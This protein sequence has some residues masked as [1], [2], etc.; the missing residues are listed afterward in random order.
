MEASLRPPNADAKQAQ[1]LAEFERVMDML[2]QNAYRAYRHL[3]YETPG[4]TDYF[5]AATP[6]AEIAELNIGSRPASRKSTRRIEDLR[7]IPWSF[8]WGQCRL[9][10]PGWYGFGSA[11]DQWLNDESTGSITKKRTLLRAML[12]E[13]P[14]FST[15]LSNMDMVLSKTDLALASRYASLVPD[16]K[17]RHSIFARI[18]AEH[19]KTLEA[20][21]MITGSRERLANNPTLARSIKNRIPYLDP[22]NHLQVELIKRHRSQNDQGREPDIRVHRGIHLSI[23]GVAAGLRNTG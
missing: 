13:W 1:R 5:F 4:F 6:I 12:K 3:V 22:L 16:R 20:L 2:S 15:L 8:S 11:V 7:A 21:W 18:A 10:L 9:L 23:N 14:F 17:L 19:E